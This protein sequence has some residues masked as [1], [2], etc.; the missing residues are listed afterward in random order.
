MKSTGSQGGF[1]LSEL[2]LLFPKTEQRHY[3]GD[4]IHW[5]R[6]GEDGLLYYFDGRQTIKTFDPV[7]LTQDSIKPPRWAA[8]GGEIEPAFYD[9]EASD[10]GSFDC[11]EYFPDTKIKICQGFGQF[12]SSGLFA[13]RDGE[14]IAHEIIR[15][16]YVSSHI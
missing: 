2:W 11:T 7:T 8:F 12:Y 13:L 10:M 4:N 5:K 14:N 16:E 6:W 3:I 15:D 1:L 9:D